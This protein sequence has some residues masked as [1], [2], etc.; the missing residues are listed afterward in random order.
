M[1]KIFI[2][3]INVTIIKRDKR[4]DIPFELAVDKYLDLAAGLNSVDTSA[5]SDKDVFYEVLSKHSL[6]F[7][8][9]RWQ[10]VLS[11]YT[12]YLEEYKESDFWRANVDVI[13]FLEKLK[14]LNCRL[15]LITRELKI[16]A[17]YK[18]RK[19]GVWNHFK[20]GGFGEDAR[21]RKDIA[22]A[23]LTRAED[24]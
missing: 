2:F 4:T 21:V 3:D 8:E 14:T 23:A 5:R 1:E 18:L 20:F 17:E 16:G 12:K 13:E 10:E 19:L 11:I 6:L 24:Y 22:S 7:T 9:D 15:C